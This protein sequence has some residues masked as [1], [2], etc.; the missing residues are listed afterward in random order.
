MRPAPRH[1]PRPTERDHH[2]AETRQACRPPSPVTCLRRSEAPA[3]RRQAAAL[4]SRPPR[5]PSS[6]GQTRRHLRKVVAT[7]CP[8]VS[9]PAG[10]SR[11]GRSRKPPCH[12]QIP[13]DR[14]GRTAE[15]DPPAVSPLRLVRRLPAEFAETTRPRQAPDNASQEGTQWLHQNDDCFETI[16]RHASALRAFKPRQFSN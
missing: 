12:R 7:P 9:R 5:A 8:P 11:S 13:I 10:S 15:P 4:G 16:S 14:T 3:S 2:S 6:P 1:K